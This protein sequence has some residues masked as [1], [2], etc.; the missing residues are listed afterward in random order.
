MVFN[1]SAG[2]TFWSFLAL[3]PSCT[4]DSG[5]F[6]FSD[7]HDAG[8]KLVIGAVC[9]NLEAWVGRRLLHS[10]LRKFGA[11]F[12]VV[13]QYQPTLVQQLFLAAIH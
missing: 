9:L 7:G 6:G 11:K 2:R 13:R 1:W 12:R 4:T 3:E 5:C 8:V 10:Y